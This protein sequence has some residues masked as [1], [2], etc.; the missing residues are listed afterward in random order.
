[1]INPSGE[2]LIKSRARVVV[3][4][5]DTHKG[6]NITPD[7]LDLHG[8]TPLLLKPLENRTFKSDWLQYARSNRARIYFARELTLRHPEITSVVV[9]PGAVKT[10]LGRNLCCLKCFGLLFSPLMK[11]P[12]RGAEGVMYC[13]TSDLSKDSGMYF[14]DCKPVELPEG[15]VDSKIQ[16]QLWDVTDQLCNKLTNKRN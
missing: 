16:T 6:G 12:E 2:Y 9:N 4:S 10:S 5:S 1:M 11:T 15:S 8:D 3:L 13:C 14:I 7:L